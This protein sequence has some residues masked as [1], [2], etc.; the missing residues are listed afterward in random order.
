MGRAIYHDGKPLIKNN[1]AILAFDEDKTYTSKETPCINCG[2]CARACPL[3]L[4]PTFIA[5]AYKHDDIEGL[6][7]LKVA[8]CMECGACS[9]VCPAKK[10]LSMINRLAKAKVREAEKNNGK[11]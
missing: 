6:K 8:I 2:R 11:I 4:M 10:Q 5:R 7:K 1:N 9:Y 3:N